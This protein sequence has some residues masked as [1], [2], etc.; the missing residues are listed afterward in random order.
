MRDALIVNLFSVVP[1]N[2][3]AALMG[4][5]AR[6]PLSAWGTRLFVRA[7]GVDLS[8]AEHDLSAYP[9]LEA[10]FT[11]RLRPGARPVDPHPDALVSPVDGRC[12]WVGRTTGGRFEL[13]PGRWHSLPALLGE[14][15]DGERDVAVLYLSPTDYHRVH[16]PREGEVVRWRYVPG[17]LWPVFPAAVRS[18]DEL[19]GR[20]ERVVAELRTDAGPL[21]VVLVGAFG[22]GRIEVAW[23]D[24]RTNTDHLAR[25]ETP[26]A[27]VPLARGAD[28]GVFHLG[29]TVVLAAPTGAWR[30]QV[31]AGAPVRV[32][33]ALAHRPPAL[34]DRG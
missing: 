6:S 18:L 1:R 3:A 15:V 16:V 11:R 33:R 13:A 28:L 12:A 31:Q 26:S 2:R 4:A 29:S 17:T 23:S 25:E 22:V 34:T 30:W 14:P 27:P 9:T 8:E 10:L 20:N 7:Y 21:H 32:G 19:F 5:L 24:L